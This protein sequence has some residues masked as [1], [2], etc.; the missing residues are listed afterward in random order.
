[1]MTIKRLPPDPRFPTRPSSDA[2]WMLSEALIE[3]DG[4]ADAGMPI[5]AIL[6]RIG[7]EPN[8]VRYAAEGRLGMAR[9]SGVPISGTPAEIALWHDGLVAGVLYQQIRTR[10]GL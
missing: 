10:E 4:R 9:A 1:M 5:P 3:M 7:I 2:F 8:E 6:D